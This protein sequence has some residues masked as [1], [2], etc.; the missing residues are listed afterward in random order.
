MHHR[1][2][3]VQE[4]IATLVTAE[5]V[6]LGCSTVYMRIVHDVPE[7]RFS[8]PSLWVQ[9]GLSLCFSCV[10]SPVTHRVSLS[11]DRLR[12]AHDCPRSAESLR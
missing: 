6:E 2:G 3:Q 8:R 4:V 10:L 1:C 12:Y 7:S 11:L 5:V 9:G